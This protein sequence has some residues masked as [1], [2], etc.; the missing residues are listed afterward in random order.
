MLLFDEPSMG[1]S[2]IMVEKIFEVVREISGEGPTVLLVEQDA[3][4]ALQVAN[5]G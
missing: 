2:S 1:L 3:R 4:L 5:R